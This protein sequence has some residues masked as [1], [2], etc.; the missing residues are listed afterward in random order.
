MFFNN[1]DE[2]VTFSKAGSRPAFYLQNICTA[3]NIKESSPGRKKII[4]DRN[5]DLHKE[6]RVLGIVNYSHGHK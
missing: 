6:Y 4:L 1:K 5:K 3:R 2:I